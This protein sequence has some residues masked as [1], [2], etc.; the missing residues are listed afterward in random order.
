MAEVVRTYHD[1]GKLKSEVYM[2]NGKKNGEYKKYGMNGELIED[3]YYT[4]GIKVE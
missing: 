4:N 3:Y 2:V 1:T